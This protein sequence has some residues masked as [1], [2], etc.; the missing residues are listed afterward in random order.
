MEVFS[1][2]ADLIM[3]NIMHSNHCTHAISEPREISVCCHYIICTSCIEWVGVMVRD[4]VEIVA[5][6]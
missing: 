2:S 3:H 5:A 6:F 1:I 4:L